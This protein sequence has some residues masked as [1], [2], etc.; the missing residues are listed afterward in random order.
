MELQKIK[1]ELLNAAEYNPRKDLKP[2]DKEYEKLKHSIL[3]FGYVEPVIWNKRT[4]N[5]VGG[6]QRLKILI[7][8]GLSEI[9][10]VIV[11]LDKKRE[12]ALNIAL[13]KIKGEWDENKLAALV[14]E[15]DAGAFDVSLTGFDAAEVDELMNQWYSK[16]AVQDEFDVDK[17]KEEIEAAGAVTQ[18]GDIWLLGNHRLMCGDSTSEM[19]F[20][21]LMNSRHAQCVVTSP[22]YGVGKDYEKK[23]IEA[24]FDTIRPVIKNICR[25]FSSGL[26]QQVC[27]MMGICL[28]AEPGSKEFEYAIGCEEK[29]VNKIP[30]GF[31]TLEIPSYTWA[32]FKCV[33]AMP[34]A[35]QRMWKRIYSEWLPQSAYELIPGYDIEFYTEGDNSSKNYI[36]EIWIPV[37]EK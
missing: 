12:K 5:V 24:W 35:I 8:E 18:K 7:D 28:P 22:P 10:C 20:E 31:V 36:S 15:L 11:N 17:S 14:A 33:G 37:K 6:H 13:N 4:G 23:G 21:K 30:E 34:E 16:E 19:D 26:H 1:T 32:V 3:E 2:G 9:D 27:G 25:Y 29:Y